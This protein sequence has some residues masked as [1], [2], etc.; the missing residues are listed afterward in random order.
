MKDGT[1]A[2]SLIYRVSQ[3]QLFSNFIEA[4]SFGKS[5]CDEQIMFFD[6]LT[7]V[8]RSNKQ[9]ILLSEFQPQRTVNAVGPYDAD[10]DMEQ[11]YQYETFL[12]LDTANFYK[13]RVVENFNEEVKVHLKHMIGAETLQRMNDQEWA[14]YLAEAVYLIWFQVFSTALPMYNS[15]SRELIAFA[16]Q[17]LDPIARRLKPFKNIEI[18]YRKL[19][20]ACGTCRLREE[21]EALFTELKEVHK[22][23]PDKITFGTHYH[24]FTL[25]CQGSQEHLQQKE[26]YV[27]TMDQLDL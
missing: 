13:P 22:V 7:G 17:L 1:K 9:P 18:V 14:R 11:V 4:R 20:E 5:D 24:A 27:P 25:A 23:D 16:R 26:M 6:E 19:I 12:K 10:L 8:K 3:T 21:V 2:N 15:H